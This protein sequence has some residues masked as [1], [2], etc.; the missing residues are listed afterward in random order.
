MQV[1]DFTYGDKNINIVMNGA[2]MIIGKFCSIAGDIKV[3][4]GQNH[5][6]DWITTYPFGHIHQGTFT[7]FS[8]N[9]H[10]ST[11]GN[12]VVGNDV[13]IG[14]SAVIMSG[15][16]IGDGAVIG[17]HSIVTKDVPPYSIF[18]GNPG[19]VRKMRFSKEDVEFL[20]ELKWW[21]LDNETINKISPLLCST[22]MQ[23]LK[24]YFNK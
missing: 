22:D 6:T 11:K 19:R 18:A 15:V 23:S 21:D 14:T 10:P 24:N 17:A 7:N 13:Y 16:T 1:G 8:G 4:L 5:R 3:Y 9:G 20:L 2:E 12:I